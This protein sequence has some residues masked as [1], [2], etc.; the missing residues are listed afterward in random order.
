MSTHD[1]EMNRLYQQGVDLYHARKFSESEAVFKKL[2]EDDKYF[3]S[4]YYGLGLLSYQR[5][6]MKTAEEQFGKMVKE[7]PD[8]AD[9]LYYLGQ[10]ALHRRAI[11]E[12]IAFHRKALEKNPNHFGAGRQLDALERYSLEYASALYRLRKFAESKKA[13]EALTQSRKYKAAGFYGIGVIQF[14]KGDYDDA[15]SQFNHCLDLHSNHA[16]AWYYI[17]RIAEKKKLPEQEIRKPYKKALEINPKHVGALLQLKRLDQ[18]VQEQRSKSEGDS[19]PECRSRAVASP[20]TEAISADAAKLMK[21]SRE[22]ENQA[23][24]LLQQ[25]SKTKQKGKLQVEETIK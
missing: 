4:G 11:P 16:N 9:A 15:A 20:D 19:N 2:A 17:G 21:L 7:L 23:K 5:G 10:I 14:Q 18:P 8:Y 3:P 22:L 24:A 12:S 6:D 13:F 25:Q 1:E